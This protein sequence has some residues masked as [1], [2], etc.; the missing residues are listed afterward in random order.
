MRKYLLYLSMMF[1][2]LSIISISGCTEDQPN[3]IS[4]SD[5]SNISSWAT[6]IDKS[7]GI[8]I[9]YPPDWTV[10]TSRVSPIITNDSSVTMENVVH[11]YSPDSNGVVQI[12]GFNY[13]V[14]LVI[15]PGIPDIVY[16]EFVKAFH[17]DQ[18]SVKSI[19]VVRDEN[20]YTINGN[21]ARRLQLS[22]YI[23]GKQMSSDVYIIRHNDVYYVVSYMVMDPS[24][25]QHAST[26][27]E[28]IKT[29]KTVSWDN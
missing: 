4:T 26:A 22:F 19:N 10:I 15:Y 1:I 12:S 2:I 18:E 20:S 17:K 25:M 3:P 9:S 28:I 7:D 27:T 14:E 8:K 6:Y 5:S 16:D 23:D 13:P 21:T 11:I 29:F 24:A